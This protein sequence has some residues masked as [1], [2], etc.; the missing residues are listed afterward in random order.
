MRCGVC[1]GTRVSEHDRGG[2]ILVDHKR[3]GRA[4]PTITGT[5]GTRTL[6]IRLRVEI[7]GS[8]IGNGGNPNACEVE[9]ALQTAAQRVVHSA[10]SF[11]NGQTHGEV[12]AFT[13]DRWVGC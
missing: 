6:W 5:K 7:R 13:D 12:V 2:R 1:R 10:V 11:Q 3:L 4:E 9:A 8:A